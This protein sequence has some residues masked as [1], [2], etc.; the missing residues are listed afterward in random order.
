MLYSRDRIAGGEWEM[1]NKV[2]GEG[3]GALGNVLAHCCGIC[4]EV[5]S[6][7]QVASNKAV[8]QKSGPGLRIDQPVAEPPRNGS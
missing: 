7:V 8:S 4:V 2:S 5:W 1:M 3:G 6:K